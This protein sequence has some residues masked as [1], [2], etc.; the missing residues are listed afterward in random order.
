VAGG[1]AP[2][3]YQWYFDGAPL[4]GATSASLTLNNVQAAQ[5][6]SYSVGVNNVAGSAAS[7][8]A[9]L[10]VNVPPTLTAQPQNQTATQGQGATFSV[11]AS[12]TAPLSYQWYC[13]S[14]ALP[15]ATS[16]TLTL[17]NVQTNNAGS[18]TVV[19]TNVAGSTTSSAA[20][21]TVN[22]PPTITAQ[23]QNQT[24][25]PHNQA[26]FSVTASG[27][28]PLAY[29]WCLNAA[30]LPGATNSA[31]AVQNVETT[32][33]GSYTVVVTNVAGSI[34]SQAAALTVTDTNVTLS[35]PEGA[36]MVSNAFTFQLSLPEG[37]T[38]VVFATSDFQNWTAVE[39]NVATNASMVFTDT[40]ASSYPNRFY[41]V[42]ASPSP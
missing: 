27:T 21:L 10:T 16:S 32:N 19:V 37:S 7:S 29:Q 17:G 4:S 18:Y 40:N 38:Y 9:T 24:V 6:G 34:T 12:G 25:K 5:A 14:S 30:A 31:L 39:T 20:T 33:A 41:E 23:P 22:V 35:V 36:G 1:A 28:G 42:V 15:G 11:T 8:S 3:S 26:T 13:N 2:L